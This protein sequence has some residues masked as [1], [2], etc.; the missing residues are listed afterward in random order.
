[1]LFVNL[2]PNIFVPIIWSFLFLM[3]IAKSELI[4]ESTMPSLH[5][6]SLMLSTSPEHATRSAKLSRYRDTF[7]PSTFCLE[8][9]RTS[10]LKPFPRYYYYSPIYFLTLF[11]MFFGEFRSKSLENLVLSQDSSTSSTAARS[12][13]NSLWALCIIFMMTLSMDV[14]SSN[15]SC[16]T[17]SKFYNDTAVRLHGITIVSSVRKL[18]KIQTL[19]H[20]LFRSYS[21]RESSTICALVIAMPTNCKYVSKSCEHR[22]NPYKLAFF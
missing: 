14:C 19:S 15:K 13:F 17:S 1:M 12:H 7:S 20:T 18:K 3:G 6:C 4:P 8:L 5:S 11:F 16:T 9:Q 22:K 10:P 2:P 21:A